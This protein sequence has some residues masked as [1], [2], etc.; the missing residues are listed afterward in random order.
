VDSSSTRP[1]RGPALSLREI[2]ASALFVALGLA[3][4]VAFHAVG[5]G[6][7]FLPMFLP[8]LAAGLWLRPLVAG[9]AGLAT[10]LVSALLTGMPPLMPPVA[11][12]MAAE[13]IAL[14]GLASF[15]YRRLRWNIFAAAAAGVLAE[16]LIAVLLIGLL[17]PL[18]GLP[19]RLAALGL[20]AE[21]LPGVGLLVVAVPLL[22]Q[23][24]E[25]AMQ[26]RGWRR[27]A[28]NH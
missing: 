24:L 2:A 4:P 13:G 16:R 27:T 15:L 17:A 18:F 3:V 23:Q 22:V 19:G 25:R 12:V 14:G 5:L 9:L 26:R 28:E 1:A 7:P 20:L 21:G 6:A 10:P 8:V 11:L